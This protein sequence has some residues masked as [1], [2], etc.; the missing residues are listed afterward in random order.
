[1]KVDKLKNNGANVCDKF[2]SEMSFIH[3]ATLISEDSVTCAIY[4]E[5]LVN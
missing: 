3:K 5:K 4:F 2:I 1:M